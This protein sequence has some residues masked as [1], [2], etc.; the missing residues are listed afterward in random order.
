MGMDID[1]I[2]CA[3]EN[4]S[5]RDRTRDAIQGFCLEHERRGLNYDDQPY[6]VHL[7]MVMQ[8]AVE[9]IHH[10]PSDDRHHIIMAAAGHDAIED[11]TMSYNDVERMTTDIAADIIYDVTN[12]L[13]KNRKEKALRTYPKIKANPY[14]LYVKLCDRISNSAYSMLTGSRMR[15][16]YRK[17]HSGFKEALYTPGQFEDMWA[18]LETILTGD[19][20]W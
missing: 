13:G 6:R 5:L 11:C 1:G 2:V 10:I 19:R 20:K 16:V 12:E 14:A 4:Y 3:I 17:E 18:K 8:Q 15:E 9:F 7:A